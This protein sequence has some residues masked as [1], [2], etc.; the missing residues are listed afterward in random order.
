[1]LLKKNGWS[2]S[3]MIWVERYSAACRKS[4]RTGKRVICYMVSLPA[5]LSLFLFCW[6]LWLWWP[7]EDR[8]LTPWGQEQDGRVLALNRYGNGGIE[9]DLLLGF[10][11]MPMR[12]HSSHEIDGACASSIP[13]HHA[14]VDEPLVPTSLPPVSGL[15]A[16]ASI[17]DRVHGGPGSNKRG[18]QG[19]LSTWVHMSINTL[20]FQFSFVLSFHPCVA[21]P[22]TELGHSTWS[23]CRILP[24]QDLALPVCVKHVQ[25]SATF[26]T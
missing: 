24:N 20:N 21:G 26:P 22:L 9:A 15:P 1:M 10:V 6:W 25:T 16:A 8:I 4:L 18:V 7:W 14:K 11:C 12:K 5:V 2:W 19:T 3:S 13:K 17:E 23:A